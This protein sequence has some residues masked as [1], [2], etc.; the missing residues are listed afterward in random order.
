MKKLKSLIL[1]LL[2]FTLVVNLISMTSFASPCCYLEIKNITQ[3]DDGI[4]TVDYVALNPLP[5]RE[6]KVEIRTAES[7]NRI[8]V[9]EDMFY[10][11][12]D[13]ASLLDTPYTFDGTFLLENYK[14][15]LTL[16]YTYNCENY[17]CSSESDTMEFTIKNGI[18]VFEFED[19]PDGMLDL[20][21]ESKAALKLSVQTAGMYNFSLEDE[22]DYELRRYP[23]KFYYRTGVSYYEA[24]QQIVMISTRDESDLS[25]KLNF[26]KAEITNIDAKTDKPENN[27]IC[28]EISNKFGLNAINIAGMGLYSF[29]VLKAKPYRDFELISDRGEPINSGRLD[30]NFKSVLSPGVY[31]VDTTDME[32]EYTIAIRYLVPEELKTDHIYTPEFNDERVANYYLLKVDTPSVISIQNPS[33]IHCELY[34]DGYRKYMDGNENEILSQGEYFVCF[35]NDAEADAQIKFTLAPFKSVSLNTDFMPEINKNDYY[36][37]FA[38]CAPKDGKYEFNFTNLNSYYWFNNNE[39]DSSG[40]NYYTREM[41]KDEWILICMREQA[42]VSV[43]EYVKPEVKALTFG[44]AEYYDFLS[45]KEYIYSFTP[46]KDD[47]YKI[48]TQ[49]TYCSNIKIWTDKEVLYEDNENRFY[50]INE[51]FELKK[52]EPVYISFGGDGDTYDQQSSVIV[53]S[54]YE[55]ITSGASVTL[56]D[57]SD[58]MV[59]YTATESG[60]HNINFSRGY[61]SSVYATF[62]IKGKQYSVRY[63]SNQDVLT[64]LN[65]GEKLFIT[66]HKFN[67]NWL[68]QVNIDVSLVDITDV[69][70]NTSYTPGD[71]VYFCFTPE[72]DGVYKVTFPKAFRTDIKSDKSDY[73]ATGEENELFFVGKKDE[74]YL[75]YTYTNNWGSGENVT[76]YSDLRIVKAETTHISTNSPCTF[77]GDFEIFTFNVPETGLY[78]IE[79]NL[80]NTRL[81]LAFEGWQ[82]ISGTYSS[83]FRLEKGF[84]CIIASKKQTSAD[85]VESGNTEIDDPYARF[86]INNANDTQKT[87]ISLVDGFISPN[88]PSPYLRFCITS[89][90]DVRDLNIGIEYTNQ[91][92]EK[93][94]LPVGYESMYGS[95]KRYSEIQ[96]FDADWQIGDIVTIKPYVYNADHPESKIYG[97]EKNITFKLR[98]DMIPLEYGTTKTKIKVQDDYNYHYKEYWFEFTQPEDVAAKTTIS[99]YGALEN[100]GVINENF[101]YVSPLYDGVEDKY[102]ELEAGK[103]YYIRF[104]TRFDD[105]DAEIRI[106]SLPDVQSDVANMIHDAKVTGDTLRFVVAEN[107]LETDKLYVALYDE[108]KV[109]M[110]VITIGNPEGAYSLDIDNIENIS[111]CKLMLIDETLAPVCGFVELSVK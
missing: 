30:E 53:K 56:N 111:N 10:I 84:N 78:R 67:D 14:Y 18:P 21:G 34:I 4:V 76:D 99:Y 11:V 48:Y 37:Y 74:K 87:G 6:V 93:V 59:Y 8:S 55:E 5:D 79:N 77:K 80:C 16:R 19:I 35:T 94:S 68:P 3:G 27:D 49:N 96:I 42:W 20:V 45:G 62:T 1:F 32:E 41:K 54:P 73:L 108:N 46:S 104:M 9:Y 100:P 2:V 33:D 17:Y 29:E 50:S 26:G 75:L 103:K 64:Y 57:M 85:F 24:G 43:S 89:P 69:S 109:L 61:G 40:L 86:S 105:S 107:S 101:E 66:F 106:S 83:L 82:M 58:V 71:K 65:Q 39:L 15:E 51:N 102:Y 81:D 47:L 95:D 22:W 52:D 70:L 91:A 63:N 92:G 44:E 25:A 31:Y 90:Y 72:T 36:Y 13:G 12:A 7:S 38:F 23:Q 97:E 60:Y 98:D 28:F 88:G 110:E